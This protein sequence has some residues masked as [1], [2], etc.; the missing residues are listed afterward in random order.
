MW[1][2]MGWSLVDLS[3]IED[4]LVFLANDKAWI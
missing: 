4:L 2:G 1:E 3:Y